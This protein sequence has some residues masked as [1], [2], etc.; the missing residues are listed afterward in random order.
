VGERED[1]AEMSWSIGIW[2]SVG[3]SKEYEVIPVETEGGFRRDIVVG[4]SCDFED[5]RGTDIVP[6]NGTRFFL[7]RFAMRVFTPFE[8]CATGLARA[9]IS[10]TVSAGGCW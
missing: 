1:D 9:G 5:W 6:I 8:G 4:G 2:L 3:S 10:A 7:F